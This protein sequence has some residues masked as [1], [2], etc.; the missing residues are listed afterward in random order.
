MEDNDEEEEREGEEE[1]ED[2][3]GTEREQ[4][5]KD[6]PQAFGSREGGD[7]SAMLDASHEEVI[8]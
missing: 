8:N 1:G 4:I 5:K 6:E 2:D 3:A 7:T